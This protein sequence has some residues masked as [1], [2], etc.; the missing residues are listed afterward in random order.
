MA[1]VETGRCPLQEE[2]TE[3]R[4]NSPAKAHQPSSKPL[5]PPSAIPPLEISNIAQQVELAHQEL[6]GWDTI[7]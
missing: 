2:N 3:Q 6:M 4:Y 5:L 1:A 7:S